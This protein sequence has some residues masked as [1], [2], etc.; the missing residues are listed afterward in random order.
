MRRLVS[1]I[2]LSLLLWASSAFAEE[3]TGTWAGSLTRPGGREDF[4]LVLKQDGQKVS[5]TLNTKVTEAPRGARRAAGTES[6]DITVRGTLEGDK[7]ALKGGGR[8][9]EATIKGDEITGTTSR[10]GGSPYN[11]TGKRSK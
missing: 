6:D 5:G 3:A 8:T 7:L 11:L 4:T 10:A 9:I 1:P 2:C